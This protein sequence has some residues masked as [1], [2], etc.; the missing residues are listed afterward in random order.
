MGNNRIED[1]FRKWRPNGCGHIQSDDFN[2]SRS[3]HTTVGIYRFFWQQSELM[4]FS[5]SCSAGTMRITN[6]FHHLR[7]AIWFARFE[8]WSTNGGYTTS[9]VRDDIIGLQFNRM[10]CTQSSR[11]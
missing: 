2:A 11:G 10:L 4:W 1:T 7:I 3:S 6:L 9:A 5:R 8:D